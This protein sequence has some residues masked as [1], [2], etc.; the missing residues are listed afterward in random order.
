VDATGRTSR[1]DVFAAGEATGVAG[2]RAARIAG[3]RAGEAA[4]LDLARPPG[5]A[6]LPVPASAALARE[7]LFAAAVSRCF[8]PPRDLASRLTPQTL[9][10]RCEDVTWEVLRKC[11]SLRAAKLETRC[12]MGHCQGRLCHDALALITGTPLLEP[13]LPLFPVDIGVLLAC[14]VPPVRTRDA[15]PAATLEPMT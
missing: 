10:C 5:Q 14:D 6:P 7:Q 11:E 9:V 4:A 15:Q 1:H 13:R 3:R 2:A 8:P 12:G